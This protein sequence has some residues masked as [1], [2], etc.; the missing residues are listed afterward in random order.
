MQTTK[1]KKRLDIQRQI[2]KHFE[3]KI[4]NFTDIFDERTFYI[5]FACLTVVSLLAIFLL[6]KF[7]KLDDADQLRKEKER[8]ERAKKQKSAEKFFTDKLGKTK[9][10]TE[11]YESI[12]KK[13]DIIKE[14]IRRDARLRDYDDSNDDLSDIDEQTN[15][16]QNLI[17]KSD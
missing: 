12:R 2:I 4:P 6:A 13:L 10:Y 15:S 9:P 16:K 8:R 3:E 5:F 7:C 14:E 11:E 1:Q 17:R